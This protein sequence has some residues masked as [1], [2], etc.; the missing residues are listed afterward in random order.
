MSHSIKCDNCQVIYKNKIYVIILLFV[1]VMN[2]NTYI[3][4]TISVD[5]RL[6]QWNDAAA[7]HV[8]IVI[9]AH[10]YINQ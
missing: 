6:H 8:F 7:L 2:Q 3:S 9:L 4:T 5:I 10:Y 1:S